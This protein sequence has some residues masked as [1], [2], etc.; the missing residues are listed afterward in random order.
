M[1][2]VAPA[3]KSP[4]GG[5]SSA[6]P[7]VLLAV[8]AWGIGPLL[9]RG[10]TVSG[11]SVAL[12]RMWLGVPA[13][14]IAARIWGRPLTM[15]VIRRCIFPGVFFGASMLMGFVSIRTTSI[16]NATLIGA[17]SP[18]LILLGVNRFV[19][20]RSDPAKIPAALVAFAGLALVVMYGSDTSGASLRG[21]L[22]AIA[23]LVCFTIYFMNL[24]VQRNDDVDGW[25]FLA[26]VFFVGAVVITPFCLFWSSD[27]GEIQIRDGV[28]LLAMVVGPGFIGHGLITWASRHLPVSSTSL[29]TLGSPVVS[30]LGGWV[31]YDQ[32]LAGWQIVGAILVIGGLMASTWDR[33]RS[34]P[35]SELVG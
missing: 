19:G 24:K 32:G 3:V 34:G 22:W 29:L 15:A 9:V 20:E 27:L 33:S 21:D 25:S 5:H 6:V 2:S 10:M 16:A 12:Y 18:A 26:G 31:V 11:Y 13:M 23:N 35:V 4:S 14:M 1:T 7:A 28:L 17:L 8:V 30:C